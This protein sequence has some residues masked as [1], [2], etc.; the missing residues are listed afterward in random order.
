MLRSLSPRDRWLLWLLALGSL[1]AA[2]VNT[3]FTQTVAYSADEFGI[4]NTGQGLGAAVVRWGIFLALPFV[5]LADR[6]GRRRMIVLL[7]WLAPTISALGALAPNFP[8]L[9]ATQTVGR[10]LGIMLEALIVVVAIEELPR[11][12]RALGTAVI[13]VASGVGAGFAVAALPVAD[14]GVT[15]WRLVYTVALVWLSVAW[16]LTRK[17][18]ETGRFV[19][20]AALPRHHGRLDGRRLIDVATVAFLTN[21]FIA[22][23]SIFQNRYLKDERDFSAM[24]VAVFTTVTTAPSAIGLVLGGRVADIRGRR[25]LATVAV[26]VGALLLAGSFTVGGWTMWMLAV[27]GGILLALA[28][29]AVAVYRGEMFPTRR[30]GTAGG[31]I[32]ASSLVGG[33]IGLILAGR[34]IDGPLGYGS[35]MMLLSIGPIVASLLVW[36]RYPET[37]HRELEEI[38]PGDQI[39]DNQP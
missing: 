2:F 23:A 14:Y 17:L 29:P 33:S 5:A 12:S 37:A 16:V 30:R 19:A 24:M 6:H 39:D 22:S 34:L 32:M 11:G 18:P 21:I 25:V 28:Y 31:V 27:S 1:P 13:A 15:A 38:N 36:F 8:I 7:A 20:R 10:P 26:P 35:T 4:D 9:V 3:V